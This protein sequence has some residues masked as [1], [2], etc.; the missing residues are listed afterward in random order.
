MN[1]TGPWVFFLVTAFCLEKWNVF[2]K[3]KKKWDKEKE[4]RHPVGLR[5]KSDV[6]GGKL[7]LAQSNVPEDNPPPK[8]KHTDIHCWIKIIIIINRPDP[9]MI[10]YEPVTLHCSSSVF[11]RGNVASGRVWQTKLF[12]EPIIQW[13]NNYWVV[14]WSNVYVFWPL[15]GA[16][17]ISDGMISRSTEMLLVEK[18]LYLWFS[19]SSIKPINSLKTKTT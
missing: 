19:F 11:R 5:V 2:L 6:L 7:M 9:R 4:Q 17:M 12:L 13:P 15:I 1:L 18:L 3:F 16:Q 14:Q 10:D 8:K